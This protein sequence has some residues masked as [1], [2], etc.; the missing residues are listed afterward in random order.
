MLLTKISD[1]VSDPSRI[2]TPPPLRVVGGRDRGVR[3]TVKTTVY[4]LDWMERA[5]QVDNNF[6][7]NKETTKTVA[8]KFQRFPVLRFKVY[9]GTN[10]FYPHVTPKSY[11]QQ[12]LLNSS[13]ICFIEFFIFFIFFFS[14]S[15]GFCLSYLKFKAT[16]IF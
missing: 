7:F 4:L 12:L 1:Q 5:Y 6:V 16:F 9:F 13:I 2:R 8:I 15:E 3:E 11:F 14:I 10:C